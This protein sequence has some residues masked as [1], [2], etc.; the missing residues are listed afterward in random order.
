MYVRGWTR[1]VYGEQKLNIIKEL[2]G[3]AGE[4]ERAFDLAQG[5]FNLRN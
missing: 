4:R 2:E 1:I 5:Q 3:A